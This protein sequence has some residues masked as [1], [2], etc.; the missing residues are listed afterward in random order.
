MLEH[1]KEALST[2]TVPI[3][4]E[5]TPISSSPNVAPR[6]EPPKGSAANAASGRIASSLRSPLVRSSAS[7]AECL[8]ESEGGS[9]RRGRSQPSGALHRLDPIPGGHTMTVAFTGV[10]TWKS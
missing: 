9:A 8:S 5:P 7:G 4:R 10:V 3:A 6:R 2:G 1:L